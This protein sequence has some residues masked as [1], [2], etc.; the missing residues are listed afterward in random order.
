SCVKSVNACVPPP[1]VKA[2]L[3]VFNANG[4]D[5][6]SKTYDPN[7]REDGLNVYEWMLSHKR[8]GV[9]ASPPVANAGENQTITLPTNSISLDGTKS[10]SPS[11]SISGYLWSKISGPTTGTITNAGSSKTSVTNLTEGTYQFQLKV[12]DNKGLSSTAVVTIKVNPAPLPP[13][14]NAGNMQIITL[15]TNSVMLDGT[16]STAP[17][18]SIVAYQWSKLSGPASGTIVTPANSTTSV[19]G[20][21]EGVY[22]FQLKVTD[23]NGKTSTASVNI[24]VNAAPTPPI[25]D[26]GSDQS[27]DLPS[28]SVMLDGTNSIAPS[29]NIVLFEWKKTSG[30]SGEVIVSPNGS[31]TI[32]NGLSM[33]IYEFELRVTDNNG[34]GSVASVKITVNSAPIPPIAKIEPVNIISLPDNSVEL[35]GSLSSAPGDVIKSFAWRKVSGPPDGTILNS[36]GA[37][38]NAIELSEGVYK[39]ELEIINSKGLS[40]TAIITVT[41]KAAP[42]PPVADAG[43]DQT[44]RLPVNSVTLDGSGSSAPS[45]VITGYAWS[46]QSGPAGGVISSSGNAITTV[47]NLEEGVYVYELEITDDNG[48]SSNASVK[49]VV[50]AAPLPPVADAGSDQTIRLPV[51]S[52]TLDGSGSSAPSGVITGYAWSKQSGPAGGVISSSG[53]AITTVSN[54]EEGV[55]VYELEITDDNGNSSNASVKIVVKAAPLPPV[56]DAGA[57]Q[58]ITLPVNSV[59]LD[60]AGSTAPG[61]S[62]IAYDWSKVSG[63]GGEDIVDPNAVM[64]TVNDLKAGVYIFELKVTDDNGSSSSNTVSVTVKAAPLPPVADAGADQTITLPVNSVTLDG[65]GSTAPGGSLI[66]YDW[67]KVSGPGGEDI[68]DPNA[69]MTTVNDLKA[70]V[71]IFELKVTDDNGSSSSNTVS[72][73]VKAAPLPPVANA[74]TSQTLTLPNNRTIL[75]GSASSAS[76][77]NVIQDY[78]WSKISGPDEGI[79]AD[80][81]AAGTSVTELVQGVYKFQLE[82]TDNQGE[83]A[84]ATVTI[85]V[86]S[87]PTPPVADAGN[88]QTI[89]LPVNSVKLDGSKSFASDGAIVQYEWSMVSGPESGHILAP[90]SAIT[91]VNELQEGNYQFRLKVTDEKGI[92]GYA[93]VFITVKASPLPPLADAGT[94]VVIT[95]PSNSVTL[96]GEGSV[97]NEGQIKKYEWVK[98]SGPA[99]GVIKDPASKITAVDQ[100]VAGTYLFQLKV[101]DDNGNSSAATVAVTVKP[102]PLIPPVADA[103]ADVSVQLPVDK[104]I[105]DGNQSYVR[106]GEISSYKWE[107]IEGPG[108]LMIL[109][110]NSSMPT[111]RSLQP[112]VYKFRLTVEDSRSLKDYDD[113]T[114]TIVDAAAVLPP[115]VAN[116]GE[117]RTILLSDGEI[118]LNG[119]SSYAEFGRIEKYHWEVVSGPSSPLIEYS[120]TDIA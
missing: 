61:G 22:I 74:G 114:I 7:F 42:L 120:E 27:I 70:G 95:L 49:I 100:L 106:D 84:F 109:N 66:A 98:K 32:V 85:T 40:S 18:G 105:L 5:A 31:T 35:D 83:K 72:V 117:S 26:A 59:T 60:G 57:D 113:V 111:I 34:I 73:T 90:S 4:H 67:S 12:T 94:P 3:T 41:V 24:S 37:V 1:S 9:T 107:M 15:P 17:S 44:I 50:K 81:N 103:G 86:N 76:G 108:S 16:K 23:S 101:T 36:S 10:T 33:G 93:T 88:S 43:S 13:I 38:A 46:K 25:A 19:S 116:A 64:T 14:A 77:E 119:G 53:N 112:G 62:L 79:I 11:G 92:P 52:V 87:A 47:S 45:G 56:A 97:A 110:S 78:Y 28:N 54:L 104:I 82:I 39:F 63:P 80:P 29:G 71:Y 118:L 20:L 51:N 115:P 2:K 102:A 58:T 99:G 68:V 75:D 96:S 55:Y 30:P 69:V 91:D 48:N 8:G 65:A 21:S 6:W 89:T